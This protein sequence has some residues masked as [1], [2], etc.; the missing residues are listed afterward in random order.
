VVILEADPFKARLTSLQTSNRIFDDLDALP[1]ESVAIFL[2]ERNLF[3]GAKN[4]VTAPDGHLKRVANAVSSRRI[5]SYGL[6]AMLP[7][8][9]VGAVMYASAPKLLEAL[10]VRELINKARSQQQL[11]ALH[12]RAIR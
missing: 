11:T 3:V 5:N 7:A 2:C 6:I 8:V 12:A 4:N 1:A 10:N 9:A